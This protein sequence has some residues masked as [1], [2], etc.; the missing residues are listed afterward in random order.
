MTRST[1]NDDLDENSSQVTKET[2][3]YLPSMKVLLLSLIWPYPHLKYLTIKCCLLGS[4]FFT[5]KMYVILVLN[6]PHKFQK[7]LW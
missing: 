3:Q 5:T 4:L 1:F 7:R 6:I 2:N